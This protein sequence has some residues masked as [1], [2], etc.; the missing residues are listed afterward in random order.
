MNYEAM[1]EEE[2]GNGRDR[3][4]EE[5]DNKQNKTKRREIDTNVNQGQRFFCVSCSLFVFIIS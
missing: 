3:W 4:I 1:K 5:E 2:L